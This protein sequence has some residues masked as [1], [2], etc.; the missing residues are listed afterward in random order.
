VKIEKGI[1][2]AFLAISHT[3]SMTLSLDFGLGRI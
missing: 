1:I 3:S 2:A